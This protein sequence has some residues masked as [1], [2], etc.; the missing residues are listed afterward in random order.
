MVIGLIKQYGG[1]D[2]RQHLIVAMVMVC[3]T[4]IDQETHL[5]EAR[6]TKHQQVVQAVPYEQT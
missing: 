5:Y 4:Y 3:G 1:G 6:N 2:G